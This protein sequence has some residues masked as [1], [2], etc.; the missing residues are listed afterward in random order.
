L[1]VCFNC[2]YSDCVGWLTH[3]L[4]TVSAKWMFRLQ[5]T[6]VEVEVEAGHELK[7]HYK[8]GMNLYLTISWA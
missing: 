7:S 3:T 1:F 6:H 5:I 2:K 4:L 8:L